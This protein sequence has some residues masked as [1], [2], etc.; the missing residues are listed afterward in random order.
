MTPAGLRLLAAAALAACL[1]LPISTCT[2]HVDARGEA[3]EVAPS[4]PVP[5]GVETLVDRRFP[6]EQLWTNPLGGVLIALAFLAPLGLR[7]LE[8]RA[9]S[10]GARRALFLA[11][12][13]LLLAAA[14]YAWTLAHFGEPALGAFVAA[15]ALA[16]LAA[17]WGIDLR[18]RLR[19]P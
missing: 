12:P 16:A 10:E 13:V 15:A 17:F 2:R 7:V 9:R 8:R 18:A 11:E 3:V 5:P 6:I 19:A 4:A 1:V 14:H